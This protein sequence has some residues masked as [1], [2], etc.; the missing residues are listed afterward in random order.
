MTA[1]PHTKRAGVIL[2]LASALM[3][4]T[5]GLFTKGV[6]AGAW[7]IIF[8]RGIFASLFTILFVASQ[9]RLRAE[10]AEVGKWGIAAG[11]VG[12]SGTAAFIPAFKLTTI[13]NVALIYASAPL[14]AALMAWLWMSEKMSRAA[15]LG[16]I[17]AIA[18]VIVIVGSSYQNVNIRGDLLTLWM[19]VSMAFL[20]VI[21]R[22][23]PH[24]PSAGPAVLSSAALIPFAL[25]FGN[26]LATPL[27]EIFITA[28]FGLV[29]AIAAVTLLEGAKRLPSGEAGLLSSSEAP[30]AIILAYLVLAEVPAM[31]SVIGGIL[32]IAGV[33]GSQIRTKGEN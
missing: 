28:G 32:I 19:T 33:A 31:T 12:A 18:G 6:E 24:I 17:A 15:V 20:M 3:F 16:S 23:F 26:P 10:F 5:A 30:L 27:L 13:A 11:F 22:R 7:E 8:W 21:Y 9:N 14:V 25:L 1:L 29:F 4:S 2:M